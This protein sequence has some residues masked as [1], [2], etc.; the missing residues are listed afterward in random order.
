MSKAQADE[1]TR[2][3]ETAMK[4]AHKRGFRETSLADIAEAADVPAGNVYY[5]FKTK[6]EPGEAVI[7]RR[8]CED[9]A[10]V[11]DVVPHGG[12]LHSPHQVRFPGSV[13]R[14]PHR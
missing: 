12:H 3:V 11:R 13:S 1:R 8:D 14:Q 9:R 7:E 5:Y 10:A 6:D 2:L 4:L